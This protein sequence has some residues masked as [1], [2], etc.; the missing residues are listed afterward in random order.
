[1]LT[2]DG[3]GSTMARRLL[4]L[5]IVLPFLIGWLRLQG[6]RAGFYGFEF[7]LALFATSLVVLFTMLIWLT[8]VSLNSADAARRQTEDALRNNER[9]FRAL[10]EHSSDSISLIDEDNRILYLSPSVAAVEGYTADELIGRNG[11]ENT[12]PDDLPLLQ[13][14]V[15]KLMANP[16]V[17]IPV[18]WR[19]RHKNGQ[20]LWLEGVATNLLNDSAVRAIVTNYRDVTGRRQTEEALVRFRTAMESS[21]DGIFLIDFKTLRLL[22]VNETGCRMLGYSREELLTMR[23]LDTSPDIT[24]AEQR[25]RFEEAKALG[26]NQVM[27]E[28]TGRSVRRKDGTVIPTEVAR[29]Y[30]RIGDNEIVVAVARDITERKQAEK[31]TAL[32]SAIVE[33]SNDAIIALDLNG[34]ITNWNS[35]AQRL[36][37]YAA[38]EIVGYSVLRLIPPDRQNEEGEM[39]ARI[40]HGD[41]V[42]HFETVRTKKDGHSIE[43]S[44]AIS[45]I[46]DGSGRVVG[47]S[48]VAR[49]ITER[50]QMELA[51]RDSEERFRTMANSIPQLAWM[52]R[53]DGYIYWYNQRW[54]EYTGKTP[55]QMEGWGWQ[56]VHDS[57]VLPQVV[58]NWTGAIAT[59]QPFEMEFPLRGADGKF[60]RFLTRVQPLKDSTGQVMQWFGTNTDVEAM[61]EV[62]EQIRQLNTALEHRVAQRTAELHTKNKELET[63]T[64]SVSHD[65]K[66]P[67]RGIDG[68]S[69]LLLADYQDKLDED[70]RAFLA[71]I[72]RAA[73]QMQQLID[74]LLNYSKLERQAVSASRID[75]CLTVEKILAERRQDLER[76]RLT[77]DL[78]AQ[79]VRADPDGMAMTLRNLIDNALKFSSLRQTP[80]IEIRSRIENGRYIISV[81][82]NGT[83][84]DMKYHERIFQIFQRLHRSEDY[85]GTGIGLAIVHKAMERMNGRVWAQSEPDKGAIFYLDL[86][87]DASPA[88]SDRDNNFS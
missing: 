19:R 62:R 14:V 55:E 21:I 36:F 46:K 85:S 78:A 75:P 42:D 76:V 49:D 31:S 66:A 45:A 61:T 4:P 74:D 13:V 6:E 22:D 30:L 47:A 24:E 57:A 18:L 37:G 1:I 54:Y 28:S 86:P 50:R 87:C 77:V 71:N 34:I 32:L 65:L 3:I 9:R 64:Y 15:G 81:Q 7:G 58:E 29:R 27:V 79:A 39:L 83:G 59:G 48:K 33:T 73:N 53:A 52:A 12:H 8:A 10:L 82:D 80:V 35:G 44:V 84:F 5:A 11:I 51:M 70:G 25:R 88:S 26:T 20:W 56:N 41:R 17:P 16:G 38:N 72:C 63:F 69:R 23:T 67:L 60:R 43:V 40:Q 68:Y 2:A